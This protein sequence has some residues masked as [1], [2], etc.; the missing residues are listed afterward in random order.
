MNQYINKII[1]DC[2]TL[3]K[4]NHN[5]KEKYKNIITEYNINKNTKKILFFDLETTGLPETKS[6]NS[7]YNYKHSEKYKNSRIVQISWIIANNKG[8]IL[9]E[10]DYIIKPDGFII[11][12]EASKIHGITT[13]KAIE[14]GIELVKIFEYFEKDVKNVTSM[15]AHNLNFDKNVLYAELYKYGYINLIKKLDTIMHLCTGEISKPLLKLPAFYSGEYK[16]PKLTEL[17]KWC[18]NQEMTNAHN[19]KYDTINMKNCFYYMMNFD[20]N[21]ENK[22]I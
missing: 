17:Y 8:K 11:S 3:K 7:Y 14:Q 20:K 21:I 19:S 6:F 5:L 16:M 9:T 13:K 22:N 12:D 18:F 1:N 2:N 15:V 4:N 10:H